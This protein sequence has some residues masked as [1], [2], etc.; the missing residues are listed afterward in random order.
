MPNVENIKFCL[1][2]IN[3]ILGK[4][5]IEG[6]NCYYFEGKLNGLNCLEYD[7]KEQKIKADYS[8]PYALG[9]ITNTYTSLVDAVDELEKTVTE[10]DVKTMVQENLVD[11]SC[12]PNNTEHLTLD[13]EIEEITF[14]QSQILTLCKIIG[15][16]A[17]ASCE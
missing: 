14:I 2:H 10:L 4:I 5:S 15:N 6:A 3:E 1:E 16:I 12:N 11:Y 8:L 13:S 17:K 7:E 9:D